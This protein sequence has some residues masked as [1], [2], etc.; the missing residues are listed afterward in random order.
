MRNERDFMMNHTYAWMG[1]G[2]WIWTA[3]GAL[4]VVL[5]V[6]AINKVSKK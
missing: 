3:L 4:V 5:L 1:G 6:V 2:M